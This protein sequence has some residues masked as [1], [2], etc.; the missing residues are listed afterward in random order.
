MKTKLVT[1][2]LLIIILIVM[3]SCSKSS[4]MPSATTTTFQA[5]LNGASETPPN[6]STATGTATFT[7]NS[8][9]FVL[10]CSVYF[11]GITP[12]AAHIHYGAVGVAGPV[13]FPLGSSPITSPINFT[14]IPLDATQRAELL[15]NQF[16][17]NLHS[18]AYPN[19]EIRGQLLQANPSGN[20]GGG[21]GNGGY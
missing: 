14:S 2:T 18:T 7:Y 5:T 6:G 20:G 8:T 21:G 19:G 12:N 3:F 11:T 10:S 15:A 13:V 9:T 4:T 16:Y 1:S 17:V